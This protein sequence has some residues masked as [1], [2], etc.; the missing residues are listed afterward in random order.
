MKY[1]ILFYKT[2]DNFA[3]LRKPHRSIHLEHVQKSFEAGHLILGGAFIEP[4]NE[5]ALVFRVTDRELIHLF[6]MNDPYVRNGLITDWR[7]QEWNVV[8]GN[9]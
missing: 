9:T 8:I 4:S 7:I 1:F 2:I 5:A 6:A 3:K